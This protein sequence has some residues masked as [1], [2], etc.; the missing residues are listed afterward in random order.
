MMESYNGRMRDEC[1]NVSLWGTITEARD[2]IGAHRI[3]YN[4]VRPN[5]SLKDKTPS[6]FAR[7]LAERDPEVRVA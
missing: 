6:E 3:D 7:G 2:G 4:D 5:G 1:L